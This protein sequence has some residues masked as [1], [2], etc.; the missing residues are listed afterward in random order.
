MLRRRL[1]TQSTR[2]P[3]RVTKV[4]KTS[5]ISF[6][7]SRENSLLVTSQ[8]MTNWPTERPRANAEVGRTSTTPPLMLKM[9]KRQMARS[10][11]SRTKRR[12][13]KITLQLSKS[14]K[15]RRNNSASK[16]R[17]SEGSKRLPRLSVDQNSLR[18]NA[19]ARKL[20]LLKRLPVVRLTRKRIR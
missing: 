20:K 1:R 6:A 19:A 15:K 3:S 18:L 9:T 8:K 11:A 16:S 13:R 10:Q 4:N 7:V 5:C 2:L 14:K 17:K 12:S